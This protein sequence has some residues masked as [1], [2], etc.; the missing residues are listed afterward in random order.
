MDWMLLPERV[1]VCMS[2]NALLPACFEPGLGSR[3]ALGQSGTRTQNIRLAESLGATVVKVHADRPADGLIAFA[4]CEGIT[5]L[6]WTR[7]LARDGR[8]FGTDR[9]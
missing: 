2:S 8:F 7:A 4:Q 3:G 9:P 5:Q 1:M 6:S